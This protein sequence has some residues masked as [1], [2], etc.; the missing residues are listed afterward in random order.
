MLVKKY[1]EIDSIF[2]FLV[3]FNVEN[4]QSNVQLLRRER[5]PKPW[6]SYHNN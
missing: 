3:G 1:M 6:G 5:T 4:V 2:K